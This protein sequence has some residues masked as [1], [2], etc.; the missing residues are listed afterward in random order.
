[1]ERQISS[2]EWFR[3]RA[4]GGRT[5]ISQEVLSVVYRALS[6]ARSIPQNP[7]KRVALPVFPDFTGITHRISHD[8]DHE[9][10]TEPSLVAGFRTGVIL[11]K[12]AK[13]DV[14]RS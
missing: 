14:Y 5:K 11:T 12:N 7:R 9:D 13:Q 1:M 10:G 3:P 8:P 2:N 4:V 6:I